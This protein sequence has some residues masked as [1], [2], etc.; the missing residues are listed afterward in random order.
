MMQSTVYAFALVL[1]VFLLGDAAGIVWGT[2]ILDRLREPRRA[3]MLLQAAMALLALGAVLLL[4]AGNAGIGLARWFVLDTAYRV[5]G[6]LGGEARLLAWLALALFTVLPPAFLLGMSFPIVQKAVQTDLGLIGR[7]VGLI[8]LANILG[9]T[10]GALV[11]GL[12]LLHFLG[13]AGTLRLIGLAGLAFALLLLR[14]RRGTPTL[15]LAAALAAAVVLLPGNAALWARVHGVEPGMAIVAED[16]TGAALTRSRPDGKVQGADVLFVGGRWQSQMTPFLPVQGAMGA[17]AAGVHPDPKSVL[18]IGYGGGGTLWAM[19]GYPALERI[20]VVEIVAPVVDVMRRYGAARSEA[21]RR[22]F[23]DHRIATTIGD[24]RHR[25][26][27]GQERYDVIVAEAIAPKAAHSG[28][29]FSRE[30]FQQVRERLAPGG[31]CIEWAATERVVTTFRTVFPYVVRAGDALI[32]SDTPI[33]YDPDRLARWLRG[34][35][36]PHLEAGGWEPEALIAWLSPRPIES[37]TPADP[38]SGEINTDLFP[39][40]EYYLNTG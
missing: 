22:L 24:G 11:T 31:L 34:P 39:K 2:R 16:R 35:A 18:M 7:R 3:F 36:R 38:P 4:H 26:L 10:A 13:T 32:G 17:L 12:V 28:L 25:L 14:E 19:A 37:W 5:F 40:D 20:E 8:Q 30:F 33:P 23:D 9:N 6:P 1:A 27:H 29:L 15:A 21:V